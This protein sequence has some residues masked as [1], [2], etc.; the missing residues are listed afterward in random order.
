MGAVMAALLV[1]L[2]LI[3]WRGVG[4]DASKDNPIKGLPVPAEYA[5]AVIVF[6]GL[7]LFTGRAAAPA[8]V[9]AW[10]LVVATSLNT[11]TQANLPGITF[12]SP[13]LS[14]ASPTQV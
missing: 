1:E 9:F 4:S 12:L 14:S 11:F 5:G 13:S 2:G 3:T 10:G 8:A 7:A 6:G